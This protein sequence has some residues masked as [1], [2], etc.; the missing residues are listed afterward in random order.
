MTI[1]SS[2]DRSIRPA[3]DALSWPGAIEVEHTLE[4]SRPWRLPRN[5]IRLFHAEGLIERAVMATGVRIR[6]GTDSGTVGGVVQVVG[7]DDDTAVDLIVDGQLVGS[8]VAA[9]DTPF[10]FADLP[11]G[12]KTVEL[13]LPQFGDVRVRAVTVERAARVWAAPDTDRPKLLTYGSSITQCRS[14]A[15]PARTWPALV[16]RELDTDLTCLGF[17]GQCHLDPMV[18]RL[19]RDRPADLIVTCLGIN[20]YGNGSFNHRSL[21]PAV[22]GFLRTVRDGHPGTPI[23]VLSPI[24]SPAR[25]D[26]ANAAGLSLSEVRAYVHDAVGLLQGHGDDAIHEIDGREVLGADQ[27][28]DLYDGLHPSAAGY[29]LMARS[30]I[31]PLRRLLPQH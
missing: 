1:G 27:S 19:I 7:A 10:A 8:R 21:V 13:W 30:L 14:A 15:S 9:A 20:V 12:D 28:H 26:A 23:V 17:G 4:W 5:E 16:A 22:I 2:A 3:D 24:A 11:R 31:E 29:E 25:E 6:F 18:A